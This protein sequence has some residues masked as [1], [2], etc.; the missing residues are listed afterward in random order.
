MDEFLYLEN[1]IFLVYV[2][3]FIMVL[4]GSSLEFLYFVERF[5]FFG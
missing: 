1:E 5:C 2:K 3:Y 4:E